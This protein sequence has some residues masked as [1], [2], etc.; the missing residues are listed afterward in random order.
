MKSEDIKRLEDCGLDYNEGLERFLGEAELFD[1]LL[2]NFLTDNEFDEA[3]RC[4][5]NGDLKGAEKAVHAMKST[6]GTLSMNGLYK[7]CCE[8]MDAIREG[9]A[10]RTKLIFGKAYEEYKRIAECLREIRS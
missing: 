8:A 6:T 3:K 10:E 1:G 4:V 5:D 7:L 9:D 2:I